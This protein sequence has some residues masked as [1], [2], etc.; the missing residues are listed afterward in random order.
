MK[1]KKMVLG[2]LHTNAFIVSNHNECLIIDPGD[3]GK[4]INNYIESEELQVTAILLTHGHF[5]HMG[6]VDYLYHKYHCPIYIHQE[7]I[8]MLKDPKINLSFFETPFIMQSPVIAAPEELNLLGQTITWLHLPGHTPGSCM[9]YFKKEHVIFAGDVLFKGSIGRFDF[10]LSSHYD[11]KQSLQHIKAMNDIDA[12]IYPGHGESTTLA[13][14]KEN[15]P[16]LQ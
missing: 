16:Y 6:A 14:E 7:D 13:Q 3:N 10:P 8:V 15:N 11:T 2:N 4:K 5:D 9:L 1:I 12:T